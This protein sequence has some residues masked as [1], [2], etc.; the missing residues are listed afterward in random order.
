MKIYFDNITHI[1]SPNCEH[2]SKNNSI[3]FWLT[4][5]GTRLKEELQR[6]NIS[7]YN[8]A[9]LNEPGLYFV[10]VNGDPNWWCGLCL[11]ENGPP[12]ILSK[13]SNEILD[14][15]R[16]KKLR[17]VIS[18]DR[19][20]GGMIYKG[21]NGFQATTNAMQLYNL[22]AGS[23]LIIQGNSKIESQYTDWLTETGQP[24]LFEVKYS[25]HFDKIFINS[26]SA[27]PP[28]EPIVCE[29]LLSPTAKDFN[30]LNRTY[31]SHRS[32]HLYLLATNGWL[33]K[34]LVSANEIQTG[35][36]DPL[37]LLNIISS[38]NNFVNNQLIK[39]FDT[40]MSFQYPKFVDGDW[41][42]NNAAN[43]VNND[44]FKN[45]LLSFVTETKFDEDVIFLTE[46]VFKCLAYGH[47]MIVL[48]PYGTLTA[49]EKLGYHTNICGINPAYNDIKN[50]SDRFF[51]THHA[52]QT[53]INFSPKKKRSKINDSLPSI[54]HNLRLSASRN[55]YHESL[56]SVI[57][58][59]ESYFNDKF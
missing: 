40:V 48:A 31:K 38:D 19:E 49:L 18:A 59:S 37:R 27:P 46:K 52:L 50:H 41:R 12:H 58:I 33:D 10:E 5:P 26:E 4:S 51:A 53:W 43:S 17:L 20:G 11:H 16:A 3:D 21:Q 36:Q 44:I 30:S 13:I 23:V 39:D 14:L 8:L 28:I 6:L 2:L 25:N 42:I 15:V 22:P 9:D 7:Y 54:K 1:T 34:G 24:K 32:A 56:M 57:N 47:P 55:F 35:N 45:S 29:S